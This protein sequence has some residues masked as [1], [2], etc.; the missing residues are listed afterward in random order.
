MESPL[1]TA[2]P[3]TKQLHAFGSIVG[4]GFGIIGLWPWVVRGQGPRWWALALGLA[5]VL[6]ALVRP[7]SLGLPYRV[8]MTLGVALG[9]INT[10]IILAVIFYGLVTPIGVVIRLCGRDPMGR[11]FDP[12]AGS[13]RVPSTPRPGSHMLRQF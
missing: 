5:L 10:R 7:A 1:M 4:G 2:R 13:Y 11:R 3:E 8:W 9:W 6:A 12:T